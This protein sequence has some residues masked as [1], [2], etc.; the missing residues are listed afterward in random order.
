MIPLLTALLA[1]TIFCK[2]LIVIAML[3]LHH[4]N[5]LYI[6][7]PMRAGIMAIAFCAVWSIIESLAIPYAARPGVLG[8]F[9][10]IAAVLLGRAFLPDYFGYS[11]GPR[12]GDSWKKLDKTITRP[13][14]DAAQKHG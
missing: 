11:F 7:P 4:D 14:T 9:A 1:A 12:S 8:L 10:S 6:R 2:I 5:K 3:K 13:T